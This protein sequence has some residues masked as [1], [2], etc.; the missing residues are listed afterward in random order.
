MKKLSDIVLGV[1]DVSA[2]QA[3]LRFSV[4]G[5]G[6]EV[7]RSMVQARRQAGVGGAGAARTHSLFL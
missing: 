6:L 2:T 3:A 1:L 7:C 4:R 5:L